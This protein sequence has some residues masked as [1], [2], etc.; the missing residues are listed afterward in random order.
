[1]RCPAAEQT[2]GPLSISVILVRAKCMPPAERLTYRNVLGP[3][4]ENVLNLY[5][6][7]RQPPF[8]GK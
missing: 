5:A 2:L 1:M 4:L 8:Y 3:K 7:G 6:N